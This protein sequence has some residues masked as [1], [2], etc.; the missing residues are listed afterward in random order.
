MTTKYRV[1]AIK[2]SDD[3][4]AKVIDQTFS[5]YDAAARAR[6]YLQ[7]KGYTAAVKV[8]VFNHASAL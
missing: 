1:N 7:G 8:V 4:A 3:F 2:L 5:T 6:A